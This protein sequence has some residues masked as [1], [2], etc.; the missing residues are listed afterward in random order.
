MVED[1]VMYYA[2]SCTWL[3]ASYWILEDVDN[4]NQSKDFT[5]LFDDETTG[6][7]SVEGINPGERRVYNLNGQMMGTDNTNT[8]RKG[9]Y[10]VNGKKVVIR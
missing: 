8:L 4:V 6:I 9:V 10:I 5:M 2:T 7:G 1:G 3:Y